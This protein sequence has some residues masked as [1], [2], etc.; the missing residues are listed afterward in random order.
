MILIIMNHCEYIVFHHIFDE[1]LIENIDLGVSLHEISWALRIVNED[2][3]QQV[4]F[5]TNISFASNDSIS[6]FEMLELFH[7]RGSE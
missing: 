3:P 6:M 1:N 2:P 7:A 5:E 4:S